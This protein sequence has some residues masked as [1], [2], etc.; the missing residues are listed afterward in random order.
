MT[1]TDTAP[2]AVPRVGTSLIL[3]SVLG[4]TLGILVAQFLDN[5]GVGLLAEIMGGDAVVFNNRVELEGVSDL[6]WAGGFL[7]CLIVGF[8]CLIAYPNLRDRGAG[9]L[10]FLWVL[11]HTLRQAMTAAINLPMDETSR[12]ARAYA[13]LEAP[14]GLDVVI[15]AG[16]AIGLLLIALS[17]AAAFLAF[18]PHRK[19]VSTGKKRLTFALWVILIPAVAAAFLAIP[20]FMPDAESLVVRMLP[21]TPIMFLATLAAAPGTTTVQGPDEERMTRFPWGL[22]IFLGVVL[23]VHVWILRGGFSVDPRQWG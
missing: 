13:T 12:L 19:V 2:R 22:L 5:L 15:A 23:V 8:S 4:S 16:G 7:L 3:V 6:A 21:F 14:G 20:F 9:R 1:T 18:A 11:L 10:V 17:A